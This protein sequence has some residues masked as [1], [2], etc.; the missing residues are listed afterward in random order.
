M[1]YPP[2]KGYDEWASV[3]ERIRDSK[4]LV[5]IPS[6]NSAPTIAYVVYNAVEGLEA[7]GVK[8][9]VVVVDGLS[10]DAT[11]NVVNAV[12]SEL[13]GRVFIIP[14]TVSPGKGGAMK[15]AIDIAYKLNVDTLIFLDSDLRSITPEWVMLLYKAAKACG[16]ATPFYKRDRYDATITNFV[17]RPLTAMAFLVDINQP[18]G[19]EFGLSRKLI[20]HLSRGAP[21]HSVYWNLLFGTDIFITLTAL[22]QGITP[23]QAFL[24]SKIHETKDPALKLRGM[25]IEVTGSLFNAL[26]EYSNIWTA[27]KRSDLLKPETI[28]EPKPIFIPPPRIRVDVERAFSEF[29]IITSEDEKRLLLNKMSNK[30]AEVVKSRIKSREG[31]DSNEWSLALLEAFRAFSGALSFTAKEK[32]LELLYHLWQGRLYMYYTE[33]LEE[34]ENKVSSI[35]ENQLQEVVK[36]RVNYIE[37]LSSI[38]QRQQ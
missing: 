25:F 19:G 20:A 6:K 16:F 2:I 17:A 8:G 28:N 23:C 1:V 3:K 29:A 30:L 37:Y 27:I 9:A 22:A 36:T 26:L 31:L 10:S 32:M 4:V 13:E 33:T 18:I 5:A 34:A 11:V 35:L 38:L 24:G 15:L 14:N 12:K 7:I 21:W